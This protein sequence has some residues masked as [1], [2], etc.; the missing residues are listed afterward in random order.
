[1]KTQYAFNT[2]AQ[3]LN[4]RGANEWYLQSSNGSNS[5][6]GGWYVLMPTNLLYAWDGVSIAST[7]A[8]APVADFTSSLYGNVNVYA[9]P[10]LL[11]NATTTDLGLLGT[12]TFTGDNL[13]LSWSS[14]FVGQFL[15]T[16]Y[17]WDGVAEMQRTF[18]VTV[19]P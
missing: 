19:G 7:T 13:N 9:T 2:A 17:I 5:A 14:S 10:S 1:L 18:L 12:P 6:N 15:V 4:A 8:R 11:T 3:A 16:V